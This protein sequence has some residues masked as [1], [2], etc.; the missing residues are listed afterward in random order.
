MNWLA[1]ISKQFKPRP[2]S[3]EYY[4]N[5]STRNTFNPSWAPSTRTVKTLDL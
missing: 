5:H 1:Q 3:V 2:T 4:M